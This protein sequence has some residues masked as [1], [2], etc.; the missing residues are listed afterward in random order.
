M[1]M[2]ITLTRGM[3]D[4]LLAEA[5]K[6]APAECCGVLLGRDGM[7]EQAT[8]A[9]NVAEDTLRHFEIDPQAL[10]DAY[11]KARAG[12]LPV[13]GYYHSHPNGHPVPS[14]T[15]C[16]HAGNGGAVWA[17]IAGGAVQFWREKQ[18]GFDPL[19]YRVTDG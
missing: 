1:G 14:A 3:Y 15:D 10:I 8:A 7:V 13:L 17:I 12:G 19:S 16:Q 4:W 6:A 18:G 11:R 5:A 9:A 2:E